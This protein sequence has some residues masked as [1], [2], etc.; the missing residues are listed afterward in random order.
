M[1]AQD[2]GVRWEEVEDDR[3]T[4]RMTVSWE[5]VQH[6]NPLIRKGDELKTEEFDSEWEADFSKAWEYT[7]SYFLDWVAQNGDMKR[8]L[9]CVLDAHLLVIGPK[10]EVL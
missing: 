1:I 8:K 4:E 9:W 7:A 3:Q 5:H 2:I 6:V 10:K